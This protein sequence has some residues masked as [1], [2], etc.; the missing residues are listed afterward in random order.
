MFDKS[1]TL[2]TWGDMFHIITCSRAHTQVQRSLCAY[3]LLGI[4]GSFC[5]YNIYIHRMP[6]KYGNKVL[7]T[8]KCNNQVLVLWMKYSL[9]VLDTSKWYQNADIGRPW[10][11]LG[12]Y[13]HEWDKKRFLESCHICQLWQHHAARGSV[14]STSRLEAPDQVRNN[15]RQQ[16]LIYLLLTLESSKHGAGE[17]RDD[18][19]QLLAVRAVA[20]KTNNI[21]KRHDSK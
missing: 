7:V 17:E 5:T 4:T 21:I 8:S 20:L 11:D 14:L 13:W 18:G 6:I 2:Y 1:N 9:P 19:T 16:T 12:D 15:N 3:T 10:T